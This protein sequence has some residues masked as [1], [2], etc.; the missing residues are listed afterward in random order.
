MKNRLERIQNG[1]WGKDKTKGMISGPS[2]NDDTLFIG[3]TFPDDL[4]NSIEKTK[5]QL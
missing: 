2:T 4:R 1:L 5:K 3:A